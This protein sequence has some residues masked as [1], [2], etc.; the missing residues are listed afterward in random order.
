MKHFTI[1]QRIA[2]GFAALLVLTAAL[3]GF[4]YFRIVHV[5]AA[6][7]SVTQHTL[8]TITALGQIRSLV[9]ENYGNTLRHAL[10]P[11]ENERQFQEIEATM[12]QVSTETT[13]VY[14]TLE[15]LIA[16]P[17]ERG[18]FDRILAAREPYTKT[19]ADI[20]KQSRVTSPEEMDAF[21]TRDLRP[22][23]IAYISRIDEAV[24]YSSQLSKQAADDVD[25]TVATAKKFIATG[26]AAAL[27]L[28]V[29][30]AWWISRR[31]SR[32]LSGLAGELADGSSEVAAAAGQV[33]TSSQTLA[34]GASEQAASLEETSASLEEI[35]SMTKRNAEAAAQAKGLA[36]QT[37]SAAE[38]GAS[39]VGAM[40]LAMDA[41]KTSSGNIAK[42]IKTIDEIAFQTNILALNAAVE[43]ARAGEAG[44]G[45]AVVAEEV[46]ALAQRS[47]TAAKETAAK[48]EDA[49]TKSEHGA[50]ISTKVAA[51]LGEIVDKA[52]QVDGLIGEIAQASQEQSQ[53]IGQVLTAVTQMDH[54][55]QGNASAAEEGAAAAEELNAQ[56][57]MMDRAVA[58]LK[59]LVGGQPHRTRA[60]QSAAKVA[61]VA[62]MTVVAPKISAPLAPT[63]PAVTPTTVHTGGASHDDFFK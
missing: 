6:S 35:S 13:A 12:K 37:R 30:I 50:T 56:A 60:H 34:S 11:T 1:A 48:I 24:A 26:L 40:N 38:T 23:Y 54:V 3:G 2:A 49:I 45:F 10:T 29:G 61:P 52:R 5:E 22:L 17:E 36:N 62:P 57:Q 27:V 39:D 14:T 47:A 4:A 19:R 28:G 8:P 44:A 53:G 7:D 58:D 31:I 33:S 51:S 63:V 32:V 41:I 21:F 46:R 20:L 16:A 9:K 42:I 15:S 25:R 18:N 59:K 55:T 43:A